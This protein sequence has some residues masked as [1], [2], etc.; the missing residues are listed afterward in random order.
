MAEQGRPSGESPEPRSRTRREQDLE[1][2]VAQFLFEQEEGARPSIEDYLA[3]YP[4]F[5]ADLAVLLED[6]LGGSASSTVAEDATA[7]VAPL[8]DRR[9]PHEI[10]AYEILEKIAEGGGG[11]VYRARHRQDHHIVALKVLDRF[12]VAD[13]RE[14]ERFRREARV[15]RALELVGVV[16]AYEVGEEDGRLWMAMKWI[17]GQ[18]LVGLRE[19][20][21]SKGHALHSLK[22]R[23]RLIARL[24]RTF[25]AVHSHGIVHRDVKPSNILVDRLG[26]PVIIDFGIARTGEGSDLTQTIDGVMGTPRYLAPELLQRGNGAVSPQSD[27][28]GLGLCLYELMTGGPAFV[29]TQ[30]EP[31]FEQIQTQGPPRPS[32]V[33][34]SIPFE[35]ESIILRATEIDPAR[36]Y[37]TMGDLAAD[38]EAFSR[39]EMPAKPT[40]RRARPWRRALLR[41]RR[42][43]PWLAAGAIL[44]MAC[45]WWGIQA[46]RVHAL[47]TENAAR[48]APWRGAPYEALA[49]QES[50]RLRDARSLA[51][52][53]RAPEHRFQAAWILDTLGH[54]EEASAVLGPA[55][56]ADSGAMRLLR[57]WLELLLNTEESRPTT[58]VGPTAV[59]TGEQS[60]PATAA[61]VR[62][63]E[64]T[65]QA[66]IR[67]LAPPTLE[68]VADLLAV[69]ED[70]ATEPEGRLLAAHL[71]WRILTGFEEPSEPGLSCKELRRAAN[72]AKLALPDEPWPTWYG[73]VAAM[74]EGDLAAARQELHRFGARVPE[75]AIAW[76]LRAV[77]D[78]AWFSKD[79]DSARALEAYAEAA[80]LYGPV[81]PR[82]GILDAEPRRHL[83]AAWAWHAAHAHGLAE[84]ERAIVAWRSAIPDW[85]WQDEVFSRLA[86][87][88]ALELAADLDGA[89]RELLTAADHNE[90][91]ALPLVELARVMELQSKEAAAERLLVEAQSRRQKMPA[92]VAT[93]LRSMVFGLHPY[94]V[95]GRLGTG[96]QWVRDGQP[97]QSR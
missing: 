17:E 32:A 72:E 5:A 60:Y 35:L 22:E 51:M 89:A 88:K 2:V 36:R 39:G 15:L 29:Q 78:S 65:D 16:P 30:R 1:E 9:T 87:A 50:D 41:H 34:P 3:R 7:L 44:V 94:G 73:A 66:R 70:R 83:L 46:W 40:L 86:R 93:Y 42:K 33:D 82:G 64:E 37:A 25:G 13:G 49:D 55:E 12:G 21:K 27:L 76:H 8:R 24:A 57:A 19:A 26:E 56:P 67:R 75:S 80:R 96:W 58:V 14:L 28:Y 77:V 92:D 95:F 90:H 10:G 48:L 38:L 71:R 61:S 43:L 97:I 79:G 59:G 20:V 74:G 11:V 68:K 84:V 18:T 53:S 6:P 47:T 23:A 85:V 81:A 4:R 91:L 63:M 52:R 69:H 54:S 31:L 45:S 62:E